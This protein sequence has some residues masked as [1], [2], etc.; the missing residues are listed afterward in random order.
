MRFFTTQSIAAI[1]WDTSVLPLASA[2]LML[3]IREFGAMPT[4]SD[5]FR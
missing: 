4:K 3:M 5:V 1:T 2:T